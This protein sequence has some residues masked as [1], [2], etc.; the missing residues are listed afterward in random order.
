M[1]DSTNPAP[2][3]VRPSV[4]AGSN[5]INSRGSTPESEVYKKNEYRICFLDSQDQKETTTNSIIYIKLPSEKGK[6]DIWW[7][8]EIVSF[9][10]FKSY[11]SV[12]H[13]GPFAANNK[14]RI[15]KNHVFCEFIEIISV[16]GE[17]RKKVIVTLIEKDP[18]TVAKACLQA[19]HF[20]FSVY[21]HDSPE[22][23]P[24]DDQPPVPLMRGAI[25]AEIVA[26]IREIRAQNPPC[27][28]L[29]GS[30]EIPVF[31]NPRNKNQFFCI[32]VDQITLWTMA[33]VGFFFLS[34]LFSLLISRQTI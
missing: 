4:P 28:C 1:A 6:I 12:L 7:D 31:I 30:H 9:L 22:A 16:P 14:V 13:G 3:S 8:I 26:N 15:T 17:E 33:M 24:E 18:N 23:T 5:K 19:F 25:S 20:S 2:P 32:M 21:A 34:F 29:T 11:V 10:E 27:K